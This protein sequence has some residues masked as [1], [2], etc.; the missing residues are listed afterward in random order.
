MEAEEEGRRDMGS[1]ATCKSMHI[2]C[3][4]CKPCF[5][6]YN[7]RTLLRK[8]KLSLCQIAGT[9]CN[10]DSWSREWRRP[11]G[12]RVRC[13]IPQEI[14]GKTRSKCK[15]ESRF[16]LDRHGPFTS[17]ACKFRWYICSNPSARDTLSCRLNLPLWW[18]RKGNFHHKSFADNNAF[19]LLGFS[20]SGLPSSMRIPVDRSH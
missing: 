5:D 19:C 6:A 17:T 13:C 15:F 14:L 11:Y 1:I 3:M 9:G 2:L 4:L 7:L 16:C 12:V 8:L 20:F 10:I 18:V